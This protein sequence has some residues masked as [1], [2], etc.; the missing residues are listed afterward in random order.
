MIFPLFS[1]QKRRGL[2]VSINELGICL[3]LLFAYSVNVLFIDSPAG[4]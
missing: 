1:V 2:L 4:W 3:G